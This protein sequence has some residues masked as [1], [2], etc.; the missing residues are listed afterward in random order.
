[1]ESLT[2]KLEGMLDP[3]CLTRG[4]D[5]ASDASVTYWTSFRC[6]PH[7][8]ADDDARNIHIFNK[9]VLSCEKG[10]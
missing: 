2:G 8:K 9:C 1:M 3:V 10:D 6:C 5:A 4:R 7:F